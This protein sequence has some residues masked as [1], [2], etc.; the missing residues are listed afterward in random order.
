MN[1]MKMVAVVGISIGAG[2]TGCRGDTDQVPAPP[3]SAAPSPSPP[4]AK[5]WIAKDGTIEMN[6]KPATLDVVGAQLGDLAQRQGVVLY[7]R[8]APEE[9]PHPNG[10][11]VLELVVESRLP[12]RMSTRR[13]FSDSV[14]P[15]GQIAE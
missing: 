11:K 6:G 1:L 3:S 15:D 9:E 2:V 5:I 10:I 12:I 7:G 4:S 13:D 14:G 8:D